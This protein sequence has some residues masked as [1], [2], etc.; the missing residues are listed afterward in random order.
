M[1][2]ILDTHTHFYDPFRPQG[3]P[4]PAPD[5]RLLYRTVLPDAFRALAEPEGVAGTIAIEASPWPDDNLWLLDLVESEPFVVG[6]V[7]NLV[8]GSDGFA[9]SLATRAAHPKFC[10]IRCHG[11]TCGK[12]DAS[13]RRDMER[14][15][16]ADLSMDA[17]IG[18]EQ[19]EDVLAV[20]EAIPGLRIVIDHLGSMPVSGKALESRWTERYRRAAALP[21]VFMKAS[22]LMFHSGLRPAPTDLDFYRPTLD[23][24]W[25]TFGADRLLY[26]SDWPVCEIAGSYAATI[27]LVKRYFAEKGEAASA[28]F[29]E[30]NARRVYRPATAG[31][32]G[33][34][35]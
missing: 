7:G 15:A 28:R 25:E 12:I 22:A 13:A 5:D 11:A 35:R 18:P 6:V 10:G 23:T 16:D 30:Q 1:V 9:A 19:F 27:G 33:G 4:W 21:N 14:L 29:F 8:P 3:V 26:A 34:G 2:P 17:L 24:L 20:A 31:S 32:S